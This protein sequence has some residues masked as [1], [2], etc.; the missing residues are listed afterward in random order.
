MGF[1]EAIEGKG[2]SNA[3]LTHRFP[4]PIDILNA[5][6]D[7]EK[8]G[9]GVTGRLRRVFDIPKKPPQKG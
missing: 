5:Q 4:T 6:R 1:R 9:T 2:R 8:Y 3:P 7:R